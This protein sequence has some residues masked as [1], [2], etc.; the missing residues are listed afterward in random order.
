[1]VAKTSAGSA[2]IAHI[3]LLEVAVVCIT[4]RLS[5]WIKLVV[6]SVRLISVVLC[7]HFLDH[8]SSRANLR[9]PYWWSLRIVLFFAR[10]R[11]FLSCWSASIILFVR[12]CLLFH[13]NSNMLLS[14][15]QYKLYETYK[16][17]ITFANISIMLEYCDFILNTHG[18]Q[19]DMQIR[20]KLLIV[21][22]LFVMEVDCCN[23]FASVMDSRLNSS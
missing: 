8:S 17:W 23:I 4:L 5:F 16:L 3:M 18:G 7:L 1:M 19:L 11:L 15:T 2:E 13:P 22:F 20:N 14:T 10:A 21:V 6:L 12:A 9:Q